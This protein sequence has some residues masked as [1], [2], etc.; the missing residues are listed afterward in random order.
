LILTRRVVGD[1]WVALA[2]DSIWGDHLIPLAVP[3]GPEVLT[4]QG[5]VA[6]GSNHGNEYE[7]PVALKRSLREI[8][9]DNVRGRID[10]ARVQAG[11]SVVK[12]THAAT[13]GAVI[14]ISTRK[15]SLTY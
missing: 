13:C 12:Q 10:S 4:G 5:I 7:G 1:Y 2:H 8:Q 3:V 14:V 15:Y 9:P 11:K 6:F